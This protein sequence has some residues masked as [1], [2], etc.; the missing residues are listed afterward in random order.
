[1]ADF[2]RFRQL[3][4]WHNRALQLALA[5]VLSISGCPANAQDNRDTRY[6]DWPTPLRAPVFDLSKQPGASNDGVTSNTQVFTAVIAKIAA[7]GGGTL[8]LPAGTWLTGPFNMTSHMTLFLDNGATLLG[9][10]DLTEWPLI[11]PM[12]S[13]GRGR[14]HDGPR[15]TSLIHGFN[16]TDIVLGGENGTV[17]AQGSWWWARHHGGAEKYT[18][19]HLFECMYCQT[20]VIQDI[21]LRNS[22]FWTVHLVYSR[23]V[24][25]QRLTVLNPLDSPNTD[26]FDPDSTTDVIL[27]DSF[28]STGDDGVAIKSGWDCKGVQVGRPS[29]NITITNLT[30]ISPTSAGV[31]IGSEMSG[32]VSNVRVESCAFLNCSTGIRI[33]TGQSRGG[34]IRNLS[35]ADIYIDGSRSAAIEINEFYGSVNDAC[36]K[37]ASAKIPPPVVSHISIKNV[38]GKNIGVPMDLRGLL[39]NPI[40]EI[41]LS[42]ITFDGGSAGLKPYKCQ[43]GAKG[44]YDKNVVPPPSVQC[45]LK[46][47]GE[48]QE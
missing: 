45:G 14:D 34:Y 36:S 22:P 46:P 7:A 5:V 44:T 8:R 40:T 9:S 1:M 19:G 33:K 10:I 37:N 39:L 23:N 11:A 24:L 47:A 18:R 3:R 13:Y 35:Y 29:T 41:T 30:V 43:G 4:C 12:P 17:D 28:F 48:D 6:S 15:R 27:R 25:A 26:G 38:I 21:T 16:L 2:N 42:N 31:C 32:G 20:I